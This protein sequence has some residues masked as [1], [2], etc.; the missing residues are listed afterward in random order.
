MKRNFFMVVA[1][2]LLLFV[3]SP[4]LVE[5]E[6]VSNGDFEIVEEG[7]FTDWSS[8]P[9]VQDLSVIS[10]AYSAELQ[11]NSIPT[12]VDGVQTVTYAPDCTLSVD[13][14][15]FPTPND[16]SRSFNLSLVAKDGILMGNP[17]GWAAINF[18]VV[19]SGIF[20]VYNGSTAYE[21][22]EGLQAVT[23]VDA[24]GDGIW[25]GETP[26]VNH[27]AITTHYGDASPSYD[28]TLNGVTV[29][30]FTGFQYNSPTDIVC[31]YTTINFM[32]GGSVSNYL[33]DNVSLIDNSPPDVP[34]DANSD[35]K[36]DGSDVTILAGNWQYGVGM[37]EPDGTWDMGDFNGDGMVDGSDVT[38]LAGNWQAGV[39]SE[40]ASVPEPSAMV[41]LVTTIVFF[42]VRSRKE[43]N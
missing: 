22:V 35:G 32:R 18:R 20:Q 13:F 27:L 19:E 7:V 11:G 10:G 39:T 33:I 34:G 1:A 4:V 17:I 3:V 21:T 23:T 5:A 12:G 16:S 36:V 25:S 41:L 8:S 43:R 24:G 9:S 42:L 26:E 40:A 29:S 28:V 31:D 2:T 14:A 30:G 6:L 38:I 15:C 37:E